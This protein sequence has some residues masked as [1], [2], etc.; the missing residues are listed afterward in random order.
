[1]RG[2]RLLKHL[3]LLSKLHRGSCGRCTCLGA[4]KTAAT[5]H[6][7]LAGIFSHET[8]ESFMPATFEKTGPCMF[9]FLNWYNKGPSWTV[10]FTSSQAL[11]IARLQ[12]HTLYILL[13]SSSEIYSSSFFHHYW[14]L[15]E[16][17]SAVVTQSGVP[18]MVLDNDTRGWIM[19]CVSGIGKAISNVYRVICDSNIV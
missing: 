2:C 4:Y 18:T 10:C 11:I 9:G 17:R 19:T 7:H 13:S 6:L 15:I 1:M 14:F 5:N 12:H 8:G 3:I 16:L